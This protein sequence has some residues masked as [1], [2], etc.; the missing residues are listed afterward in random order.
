VHFYDFW[1]QPRK[2]AA[3]IGMCVDGS[4]VCVHLQGKETTRPHL[5]FLYGIG[6]IDFVS[7]FAE[8]AMNNIGDGC[9][10]EEFVGY[11]DNYWL[12]GTAIGRSKAWE[13]LRS[14]LLQGKD[15]IDI[16]AEQA[17]LAK[18]DQFLMHVDVLGPPAAARVCEHMQCHARP[19]VGEPT[20]VSARVKLHRDEDRKENATT[21]AVNNEDNDDQASVATAQTIK[22]SNVNMVRVL[23]TMQSAANC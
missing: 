23:S 3:A 21:I 20:G 9:S 17:I 16:Q 8:A 10:L 2:E 12:S 14:I 4:N 22:T 11:A 15:N 6:Q 19:S 18:L 5:I 1:Y 7:T 13:S